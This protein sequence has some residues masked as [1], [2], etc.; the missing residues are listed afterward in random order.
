MQTYLC[1]P[2]QIVQ[3]VSM[4]GASSRACGEWFGIAAYAGH[5]WDSIGLNSSR[6]AGCCPDVLRACLWPSEDEESYEAAA[7]PVS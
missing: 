3:N 7:T 1:N 6:L 4:W 2:R 5:C